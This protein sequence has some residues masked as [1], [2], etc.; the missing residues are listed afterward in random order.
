[1]EET[2]G[3]EALFSPEEWDAIHSGD[4]PIERQLAG[5]LQIL[6]GARADG[7]GGRLRTH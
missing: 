2:I 4:W 3:Y 7:V 5:G 6:T 1:V